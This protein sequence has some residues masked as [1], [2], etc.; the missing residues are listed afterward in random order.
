MSA[1]RLTTPKPTTVR[2]GDHDGS[3]IAVTSPET[4]STDSADLR[5]AGR[6]AALRHPVAR[7]LSRQPSQHHYPC[8]PLV[9]AIFVT[10]AKLHL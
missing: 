7:W 5:A 10:T 3:A 2:H 8:A 1:A 9:S 4:G 6:F